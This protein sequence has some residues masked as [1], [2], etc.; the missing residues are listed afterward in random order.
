MGQPQYPD[1]LAGVGYQRIGQ[2]TFLV[3]LAIYLY[4][5]GGVAAVG[6]SAAVRMLPSVIAVPLL[7]PLI[8]RIQP[9]RALSVIA[10]GRFL[11]VGVAAVGF[12]SDMALPV[13]YVLVAIEEVGTYLVRPAQNVLLPWF[14]R[15]PREFSL[16]NLG[17]SDFL[18]ASSL[19][20]SVGAAA[21]LAV[22]SSAWVASIAAAAYLWAMLFYMWLGRRPGV[23][24]PKPAESGEAERFWQSIMTGLRCTCR[25]SSARLVTGLQGVKFFVAGSFGVLAVAASVQLLGLGNSGPGI[26]RAVVSIGG[27]LSFFMSGAITH[28]ARLARILAIGMLAYGLP[29]VF[30]GTVPKPVV[31]ALIVLA[32]V[33]LGD[34][35]VDT[36]TYTLIQRLLP[37][38]LV[39]R[40]LG[41]N[42][43]IG[44]LTFALG[45]L[46]APILVRAIGLRGS[47][48]ATGGAL[49]LLG[50]F[51]WPW[52]RRIDS[53]AQKR[54]ADF[55]IL[56]QQPVFERL[57]CWLSNVSQTARSS[58]RCRRGRP[59]SNKVM[60]A[61]NS[62]SFVAELSTYSSAISY[63]GSWE[64]AAHSGR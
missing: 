43:S 7:E 55:D 35:M 63:C 51:A 34:T 1:S 60:R 57:P 32:L 4:H 33:G 8:D 39:G 5:R 21:L 11:A 18:Y 40:V 58:D 50:V 9:D 27:I 59:S 23:Q 31:I 20:G 52:L 30:L 15:T 3:A 44:A 56:Q 53:A 22:L 16:T 13:I 12:F 2:S 28:G 41:L 6:I 64:P 62:S 47:L 37:D 17:F 54:D 25:D 24:P 29:Q 36:P 14:A 26:Y 10:W 19:I 38:A 46:A 48:V 45:S 61:R 49:A 42:A